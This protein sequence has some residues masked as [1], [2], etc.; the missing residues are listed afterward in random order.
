MLDGEFFVMAGS[1]A[2]IFAILFCVMKPA[3]ERRYPRT[4]PRKIF[5]N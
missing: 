2:V 3:N 1:F 4:K 5:T